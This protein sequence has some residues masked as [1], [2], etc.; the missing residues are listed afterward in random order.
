MEDQKSYTVRTETGEIRLMSQDEVSK[1]VRSSIERAKSATPRKNTNNKLSQDASSVY[2]ASTATSRRLSLSPRS[3]NSMRKYQFNRS[4]EEPKATSKPKTSQLFRDFREAMS[5]GASDITLGENGNITSRPKTERESRADKPSR[6]RGTTMDDRFSAMVKSASARAVER[7]KIR[8]QSFTVS[9]EAEGKKNLSET[10]INDLVRSSIRRARQNAKHK[11]WKQLDSSYNTASASIPSNLSYSP[12]H[13]VQRKFS[14]SSAEKSD[15]DEIDE[16]RDD[17]VPERDGSDGRDHEP[18]AENGQ[19][20]S[21]RDDAII[22]TSS[23]DD[24]Q[25]RLEVTEQNTLLED[26]R[27]ETTNSE[28]TCDHVFETPSCSPESV[29]EDFE[30]PQ[31]LKT[32]DR[33]S[34]LNEDVEAP[35]SP[36]TE[37]RASDSRIISPETC[38][39]APALGS[40]VSAGGESVLSDKDI[41]LRVQ[42]SMDRAKLTRLEITELLQQ[43]PQSGMK[44]SEMADIVEGT[45]R[46]A[47]ESAKGIDQPSATERDTE[48]CCLVEDTIERDRIVE[49]ASS[50]STAPGIQKYRAFFLSGSELK[51]SLANG[52]DTSDLRSLPARAQT[53]AALPLSSHQEIEPTRS[54]E[55][56]FSGTLKS[57]SAVAAPVATAEILVNELADEKL[58][59]VCPG[60]SQEHAVSDMKTSEVRATVKDTAP[61]D[62]EPVINPRDAPGDSC[63]SPFDC[64]IGMSPSPSPS[65]LPPPIQA[66]TTSYSDH[67][68]SREDRTKFRTIKS[69]VEMPSDDKESAVDMGIEVSV[70]P[71][72]AS[73]D[74]G[75]ELTAHMSGCE[76]ASDLLNSD[77]QTHANMQMPS[78]FSTDNLPQDSELHSNQRD[79]KYPTGELP[80]D[81]ATHEKDNAI[82]LTEQAKS[83]APTDAGV[84]FPATEVLLVNESEPATSAEERVPFHVAEARTELVPA[85]ASSSDLCDSSAALADVS[86]TTAS[87]YSVASPVDVP[88]A[89][90]QE[91][92]ELLVHHVVRRPLLMIKESASSED[93]CDVAMTVHQ[94]LSDAL[95][96]N[97]S[98]QHRS[99]SEASQRRRKHSQPIKARSPRRA[100][101]QK[102]NSTRNGNNEAVITEEFL[103]EI[104]SK[105]G[106]RI[107]AVELAQMM[108]SAK[109]KC[110]G[111]NN[112]DSQEDMSTLHATSADNSGFSDQQSDDRTRESQSRGRSRSR[113]RKKKASSVQS[114]FC[115]DFLDFF[116]Q[117]DMHANDECDDGS[118]IDSAVDETSTQKGDLTDNGCDT[119]EQGSDRP[120]KTAVDYESE[121][122]TTLDEKERRRITFSFSDGRYTEGDYDA[123]SSDDS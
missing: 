43:S 69:Q 18:S 3:P 52:G 116:T 8:V 15:D 99:K 21:Q 96:S 53:E 71:A 72:T 38:Y 51:E 94:R 64:S 39:D 86:V 73:A 62:R 2:S 22:A 41:C 32:E 57:F 16:V 75:M 60:I 34:A 26:K 84:P 45:M 55:D 114:Q 40:V 77:L 33:A 106:A 95:N 82:E 67:S 61:T 27:E 112:V 108:K 56:H 93:A 89:E 30:A 74:S 109:P 58:D 19:L 81:V 11:T 117:L 76:P 97:T 115:M 87:K 100:R 12:Q 104:A 78:V 107:T 23:A 47:R 7:E 49:C 80:S 101:G 92:E 120:R 28:R 1:L 79:V 10:E 105:K 6:S 103:S 13:A 70:L 46:R 5:S 122:A 66:D 24:N 48:H 102:S 59:T 63:C 36:K 68:F 31:S 118:W 14:W 88:C 44:I 50:M 121:Y 20:E 123:S 111:S 35:Q 113:T 42:L 91:T 4:Q 110:T 9:T 54:K 85:V 65:P 37:E 25:F 90:T 119:T 29:N 98:S 83:T 17:E